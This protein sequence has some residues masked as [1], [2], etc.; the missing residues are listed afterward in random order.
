MDTWDYQSKGAE[1]FQNYIR[2]TGKEYVVSS[3]LTFVS[4]GYF[5]Y[6]CELSPFIE[7]CLKIAS[8]RQWKLDFV[9]SLALLEVLSK[10]EKLS[11]SEERMAEKILEECQIRGLAF[12][13]FQNLPARILELYQLEDKTFVEYRTNPHARVV[14]HY[15]LDTGLGR[16]PEFQSEPLRELYQGVFLKTFTL[17][18][19]ETL[20]YY[21]TVELDGKKEKTA[22]KTF[23][24]NHTDKESKSK[25]QLL[26]RILSAW[27]LSK[28][29]EAAGLLQDYL[30]QEQYKKCIYTIEKES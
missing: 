12:A 14:L 24:M 11:A 30:R 27:R 9:C 1:I 23:V 28:G 17:F 20:Q 6:G 7:K 10:K 19:G 2:Q 5:V 21:F 22:V 26:N 15:A 16:A 4:Y 29:P 3:Y 8:R 13:F 25:Y 18:Y